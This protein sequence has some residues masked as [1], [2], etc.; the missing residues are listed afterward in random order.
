[1]RSCRAC[2][3][4]VSNTFKPGD[5]EQVYTQLLQEGLDRYLFADGTIQSF[6]VFEQTVTRPDVWFYSGYDTP[7]GNNPLAV[8]L[9]NQFKGKTAYMH[10]AF[11]EAGL[12]HR[13][14]IAARFMQ[15]VFAG[16][17]TAVFGATSIRWRNVRTFAREVGFVDMAR[18]P[19]YFT[20]MN[21]RTG[22]LEYHD[23]MLSLCTP[24]TLNL[25][26]KEV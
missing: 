5:L 13:H 25:S 19:G 26:L 8:V 15:L 23:S 2:I 17:L 11:F 16:G 18:V 10:F 12:S 22:T 20:Y 4:G 6:P 7:S 9:L 1:M 24:Q 14:A 3:S 21:R